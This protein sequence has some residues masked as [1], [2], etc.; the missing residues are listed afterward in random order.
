MSTRL[1]QKEKPIY[2]KAIKEGME[3]NDVS[4]KIVWI[5]RTKHNQRRHT[6]HEQVIIVRRMMAKAKRENKNAGTRKEIE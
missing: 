4:L 3:R 6:M 2:E 5:I 1:N